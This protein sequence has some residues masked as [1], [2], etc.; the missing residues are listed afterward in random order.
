MLKTDLLFKTFVL[1]YSETIEINISKMSIFVWSM[2]ELLERR[3][4]I[5]K[6]DRD[7]RPEYLLIL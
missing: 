1:M 6:I 2:I 5:D 3:I 7:K 4:E